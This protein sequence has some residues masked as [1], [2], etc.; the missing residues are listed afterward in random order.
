MSARALLLDPTRVFLGVAPILEQMLDDP[1]P[2]Y[3]QSARAALD[4]LQRGTLAGIQSSST[5]HWIALQEPSARPAPASVGAIFQYHA[6]AWPPRSELDMIGWIVVQDGYGSGP[7]VLVHELGHFLNRFVIWQRTQQDPPLIDPSIAQGIPPD[8][9]RTVR[10]R[11]LDEIAARHLAWLAQEGKVPGETQMPDAGALMA[12]AVKIASYP[13]V[14]GDTMLMPGL[15]R[16]GDAD[17]LRDLVG[18]WMSGLRGLRF[19]DPG[20]AV[21]EHHKQWLDHEIETAALGRN[22]PLMAPEGTL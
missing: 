15:L 13:Q 1:R 4:A 2:G 12:C 17:L 16:R 5:R 19:F 8:V 6:R 18:A 7:L 3:G 11:L 14:Y 10:A 9:V 21:A 20:T 22:A